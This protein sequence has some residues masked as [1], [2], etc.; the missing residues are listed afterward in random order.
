MI[1]VLWDKRDRRVGLYIEGHA[2]AAPK[3][4]DTICAA[5]SVLAQT[6]VYTAMRLSLSDEPQSVLRTGYAALL[7][8]CRTAEEHRRLCEALSVIA[9][10]LFLLA[11]RYPDHIQIMRPLNAE[12]GGNEK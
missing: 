2:C 10:G 9:D 3:G 12:E 1:T 7:C 8:R 11:R 5:V 4:Y 6:A